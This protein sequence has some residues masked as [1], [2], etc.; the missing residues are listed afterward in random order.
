[1]D[2][3]RFFHP[4]HK[5]GVDGEPSHFLGTAFPVHPNGTLLTCR[6]VVDV[7][8]G[9][10]EALAVYDYFTESYYPLGTPRLSSTAVDLALLVD[11]IPGK[12]E[13]FPILFPNKIHIGEEVYSFG[14]YS[15]HGTTEV[16]RGYFAGRIANIEETSRF[17]AQP[18]L[19]LPYPIIEG[20]SGSPVLTYHNGP[21]LLG[22]CIGSESHRVLAAEV[23]DVTDG[24]LRFK[25]T[26]HRITEFGIAYHAAAVIRFLAETGLQQLY[27]SDQRLPIPGLED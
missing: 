1:M 17:A 27:L 16:T 11:A 10:D 7:R 14:Y 6:H 22:V 4:V 21:K 25:E 9:T 12:A 19:T 20:L 3:R 24:A 13:F 8:L 23:S 18:I 5:L 26:I 15:R 2:P